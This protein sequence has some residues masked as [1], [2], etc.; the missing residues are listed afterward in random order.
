MA[1]LYAPRYYA[2]F[3]CK[4]DRC[5]HS[6]CVGWEIDI[7]EET[8]S[9]YRDLPGAIGDEIREA[10]DDTDTPHFR[11]G[12]DERCPLL[13]GRG[14]CRIIST[15][16]E[17]YL[18]DICRE[19]P[20]FYN[21]VGGRLEGG[22]G[23]SCEEAAR[24]ILE[25]G[26]Y[27]TLLP[28][29]TPDSVCAPCGFDATPLRARLFTRLSDQA[30]PLEWRLAAIEQALSLPTPLTVE[31]CRPLFA[32]L[33]YLDERHKTLFLSCTTPQIPQGEQGARYERFFAYLVYR[34]ASGAE[35]ER[36]FCCAARMA[37]LLSDM[38]LAL[39]GQ[40]G[41]SPV[42]AAVMISE[43]IEYSEENTQALLLACEQGMPLAHRM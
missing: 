42:E 39:Q 40:H 18:C 8:L 12:A 3:Q 14:L 5:S 16:G 17:G 24:L 15:V 33:E 4:A 22:L 28:L 2:R 30:Q 34:H 38:F 6:C 35:D 13:D 25:E 31:A 21:T 1:A 27:A 9:L 37:R 26:D 19:H 36:G 29:G 32:G 20:R 11:L 7:D 43:E 41:L 23:A 10:I